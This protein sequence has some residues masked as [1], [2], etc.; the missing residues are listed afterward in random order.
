MIVQL[1]P[2][3]TP[4]DATLLV[5]EHGST[6][7]DPHTD[8]SELDTISVKRTFASADVPVPLSAILGLCDST[9]LRVWPGSHKTI[10][11]FVEEENPKVDAQPGKVISIKRGEMVVFRGDFVHAGTLGVC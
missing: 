9:P 3:L 10:W 11:A 1:F 6:H 8:V 5:A 2:R 4:N 7:Q